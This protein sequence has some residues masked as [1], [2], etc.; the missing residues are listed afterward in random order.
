MGFKYL[1]EQPGKNESILWFKLL[2][3]KLI[4]L[5]VFITMPKDQNKYNA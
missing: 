1:L 2:D 4:A 3:I 5:G